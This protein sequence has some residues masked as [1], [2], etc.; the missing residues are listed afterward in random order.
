MRCAQMTLTWPGAYGGTSGGACS[1]SLKWPSLDSVVLLGTTVDPT[2][3]TL[4]VIEAFSSLTT[5][6]M[7]LAQ[8]C[9]LSTYVPGSS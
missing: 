6:C 9:L 7:H 1:G 3:I 8:C 5:G 2:S 4:Q